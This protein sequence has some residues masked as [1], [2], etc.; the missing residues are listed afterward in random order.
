MKQLRRLSKFHSSEWGKDENRMEKNSV[1]LGIL[2]Y[3]S[4]KAGCMY[5]SDLRERKTLPFVQNA[6]ARIDPNLF[7]LEE[8]NDAVYYITGEDVEFPTC[9]QAVQYLLSEKVY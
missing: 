4:F 2:D 8:W 3:L 9:E 1:S 7:S 6:V 5:L